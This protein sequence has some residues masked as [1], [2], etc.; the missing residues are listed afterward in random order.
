MEEHG[1]PQASNQT[2][3]ELTFDFVKLTKETFFKHYKPSPDTKVVTETGAVINSEPILAVIRKFKQ[4]MK[5]NDYDGFNNLITD[6]ATR[7]LSASDRQ[8]LSMAVISD[9]GETVF[10]LVM[11]MDDIDD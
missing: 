11:E 9:T 6:S 4:C 7:S 5:E 10:D 8:Y 1:N 2:G 3:K